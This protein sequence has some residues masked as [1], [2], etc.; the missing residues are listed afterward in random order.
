[1]Y[2]QV[3]LDALDT[4][5]VR[6]ASVGLHVKQLT[7]GPAQDD[8]AVAR[9]NHLVVA[10]KLLDTADLLLAQCWGAGHISSHDRLHPHAG[11]AKSR[12]KR[13]DWLLNALRGFRPAHSL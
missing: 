3:V 5:V 10:G 7:V 1:M 8:H 13:T 11:F 9:V 6:Q 2:V 12:E 4:E